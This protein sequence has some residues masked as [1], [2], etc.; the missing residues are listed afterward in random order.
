M[1]VRGEQEF[2]L[3]NVK[4]EMLVRHPSRDVRESNGFKV[5]D[6]RREVLD[7]DVHTGVTDM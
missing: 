7:R 4:F 1:G 5:L 6:L 3:G 2:P